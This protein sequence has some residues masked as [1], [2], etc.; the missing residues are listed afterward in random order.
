MYSVIFKYLNFCQEEFKQSSVALLKGIADGWLRPIIAK[1]Y[2]FSEEGVQQVHK[3][4][5]SD[6][7][8]HGKLVLTIIK[9]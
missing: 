1:D 2:E 7:G 6:H 5:M 9:C 4:I 3:D 8:K